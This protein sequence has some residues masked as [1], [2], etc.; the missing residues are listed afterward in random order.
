MS[1]SLSGTR[2]LIASRSSNWTE[3]DG[4]C[5]AGAAGASADSPAEFDAPRL[6]LKETPP[7]PQ[8]A[9]KNPEA[10]RTC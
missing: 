6:L 10:M 1:T 7:P 4:G 9:S 3:G 8:N 2:G 5:E